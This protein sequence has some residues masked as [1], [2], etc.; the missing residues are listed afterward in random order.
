MRGPQSEEEKN[1]QASRVEVYRCKLC[2]TETTFP[3]FNSPRALFKSRK[4]RCGEFAN[5]FGTY[6]RALGFDTRYV[7]DFTDHVWVECWSVRQQRWIHADSCEGLIDRPAMYESGWGKKLN[8]AVAATHDSVADVTKRYTRKFY[9]DDFQARRREFAP[10]ENISDRIFVQMNGGLRQMNNIGK[11]RL[12]ELDKRNEAEQKFF[13]MVQS[14]GVWDVEYREGRISGSLA[15]KAARK[16][17]GDGKNESDGEKKE[18]NNKD[19]E[20]HSFF[21]ESFL[22]RTVTSP[23]SIAVQP[24]KQ[25]HIPTRI[26][27][28]P[29]C[30]TVSGVPCAVTLSYGVSIVIV[31]EVSGCILQSKAFSKWSSAGGFLVTVPNGRIVA[32]CCVR[33]KDGD[34]Q[35]NIDRSIFSRL[36]GFN[37]DQATASDERYFLYIGQLNFHPKWAQSFNTSNSKQCIKVFLLNV[38]YP[39]GRLRS[40]INTIPSSVTT[41]LPETIMPLKTQLV[42]SNYQKALAFNSFMENK[43]K[44]YFFGTLASF[45]GYTTKPGAPVYL[46]DSAS[47]PFQK[48]ETQ[49]HGSDN[50]S[51]WTTYHFLPDA[52]VP[53]DD[54]V[55]EDTNTSSSKTIPKFDIPVAEDYFIRLL[56][57]KLLTKNAG[58][59]DTSTA[60][61]NTRLVALYFS[62]SWCG[63]CRGFTPLLVEFYNHL[64]EEVAS[65]HGLEIIFVSSDRDEASFQQYYSKMPFLAMPFSN[66]ALAQHAKQ[67]F[68]VRGIPSFVV[69][70][71]LSGRVV[72]SPDDSRKEVHQAC[73]RGEQAIESLFKT[74]LTKVPPETTSMLD[75]L[76]LSCYEAETVSDQTS[77]NVKAEQYLVRKKEEVKPKPSTEDLQARVKEIF[78]SLV[79]SGESPNEAAAQAIKQASEKQYNPSVKLEQGNIRWGNVE[80]CKDETRSNSIEEKVNKLCEMHCE[81][82]GL[83][84]AS[85]AERKSSG[86]KTVVNVLSIAKKYV[87]NVQKDPYNPRFRNFKLSNKVFDA[88]TSNRG[89]IDLLVTIGFAVYHSDSDLMASIPLTAD[90]KS[91][92]DVL[93]SL[94]KAYSD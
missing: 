11:G 72:V 57:N 89:S 74:W 93:D 62:A 79:A 2:G 15:W 50:N 6:C 49:T 80:V 63:P 87:A 41:R 1:G 84:A 67:M 38:H 59:V 71:S 48:S 64:K 69:I 46:I 92:S 42:A 25:T 61:A 30:I 85:E 7:H 76:A 68:G 70:D 14:S 19:D 32:L 20:A 28:H 17:L 52:L 12:D 47:F 73:Q 55:V 27:F 78:T 94:I 65:T 58:E 66:R 40:E 4:G 54:E 53:D 35:K 9:S 51:S 21:V 31:D 90:L 18:E 8:Y 39:F 37:M 60:L 82:N 24:P 77:T 86:A 26:A 75:I 16:E 34:D 44:Q 81:M 33:D 29:E 36:G 13:G 91:M 5:L 10:D 83:G 43:D 23:V 56:G 88:I 22:P 45:V 3:R